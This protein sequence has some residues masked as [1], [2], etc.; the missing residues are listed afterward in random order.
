MKKQSLQ[1]SESLWVGA[2]LAFSGG[3]MDAYTYLFR[4]GVFANAQTGILILFGIHLCHAD[5]LLSLRY[6][7]PVVCFVL[8]IVLARLVSLKAVRWRLHWRQLT[9]VFE[10]FV[11]CFVAVISTRLNLLAN[12]LVSLACGIQVQSFR[13]IHGN[14]LATTMCIGNIRAA[15]DY[16]CCYC[17]DGRQGQLQKSLLYYSIIGIF[18]VGAVCGSFGVRLLAQQAILV[19][20]LLLLAV[21][22]L[23]LPAPPTETMSSDSDW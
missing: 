8:G 14:S 12:S 21:F 22:L 18:I 20:P 23:M 13:K 2:L 11:L 10:I 9:V 4:D 5:L 1:M 15:T 19:C 16:L 7:C 6:L 17:F 3:Y